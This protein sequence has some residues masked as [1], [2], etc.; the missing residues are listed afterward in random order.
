MGRAAHVTE[1]TLLFTELE[2]LRQFLKLWDENPTRLLVHPYYGRMNATWVGIESGTLTVDQGANLYTVS[3]QFVESNINADAV[4]DGGQSVTAR[5]AAVDSQALLVPAELDGAEFDSAELDTTVTTYTTAAS[6]FSVAAAAT[7]ASTDPALPG[8]LNAALT[9]G[10]A[11]IAAIRAAADDGPEAADAV[12]ACEIL[13][14][15][16]ID[17]GAA[18]LARSPTLIEYRVGEAAH[19]LAIAGQ[20][21]AGD[22]VARMTEIRSLNPAV[23]GLIVPAG[24]V[25]TLAAA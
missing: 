14:A 25:L 11:T 8:L 5:A 21:Y 17:L 7:T 12:I 6:A 18:C 19:L 3:G 2:T 13:Q 24:T 4:T 10:T 9:A 1:C 23:L 15:H 16:L 20:V 22:A